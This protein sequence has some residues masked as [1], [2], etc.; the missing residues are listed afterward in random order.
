M[1]LVR[2]R[3][4]SLRSQSHPPIGDDETVRL[5]SVWSH[6]RLETGLMRLIEYYT[7]NNLE[8][9]VETGCMNAAECGAMKTASIV[10]QSGILAGIIAMILQNAGIILQRPTP[11]MRREPVEITGSVQVTS[12]P[13]IYLAD[14]PIVHVATMPELEMADTIA[15]NIEQ[16]GGNYVSFSKGLP[17]DLQGL[18]G[19][20][21]EWDDSS[22][23]IGIKTDK[24]RPADSIHWGS[25]SIRRE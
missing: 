5:V 7:K 20:S 1:R 22:D 18:A 25:V 13:P 23:E 17:I 21:L 12:V 15:V 4:A 3:L 8:N 6:L 19:Q 10:I 9:R 11:E 14:E 16:V 2:S 24:Y